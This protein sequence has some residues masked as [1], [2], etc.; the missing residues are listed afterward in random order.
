VIADEMEEGLIA[1]EVARAEYGM[2]ITAGIVLGD[3]GK[4]N[5]I[6]GNKF[7]VRFLIAGPYDDADVVDA[8]AGGFANHEA[9]DR[10]LHT[11]LIDE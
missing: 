10:A 7:R 9:E 4:A 2:R 6:F 8:G 11:L 5:R 3:E 1:D